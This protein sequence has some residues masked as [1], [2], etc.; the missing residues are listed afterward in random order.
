MTKNE[1]ILQLSNELKKNRINDIDEI[2]IDF[3][4]HF[5]FKLE[6]GKTEEEIA[7]KMGNPVD[8]AKD[9]LNQ[10][11][12]TK[13]RGNAVVKIG[14]VIIDFFT[15]LAFVIM[16]LSVL[17]LGAFALVMLTLGVLLLTTANIA[18][19]IP[20]MPYLSSFIMSISSFALAVISCI[21]TI[22]LVLY[23]MQWQKAYQRWRKNVLNKNIYPSLS[24]HPKLSK[25]M[26]STLKLLNMFGVII[27][28]S[29]FIIGYLVSSLIARSFEFWHVWNWFV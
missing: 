24:K 11:K 8:I 4:E 28:V 19:L 26:A 23:I 22:Y 14:L 16:W 18:D 10:A 21:G 25:K 6:E 7:R 5:A 20:S 15:Y 9:Y 3:E 17:V 29:T 1:F 27:F 12:A 2:I 13:E